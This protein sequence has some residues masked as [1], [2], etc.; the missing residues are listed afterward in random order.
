MAEYVVKLPDVGE[1]VAEAELVEWHVKPGDLVR[2]D[3]VLAA[4]MTDKA[5][6]EI[7]SPV[8]GDIFPRR[9]CRRHGR[10]RLRVDPVEGG[11]P[12]RCAGRYGRAGFDEFKRKDSSECRTRRIE[13]REAAEP[14]RQPAP[15]PRLEPCHG[16]AVAALPVWR[17]SVPGHTRGPPRPEKRELTCAKSRAPVQRAAS[18]TTTLMC[19]SPMASER[20]G[21]CTYQ[22]KTSVIDVKVVGLRRKIAEKMTQLLTR[23]FRT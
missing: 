5:T 14:P 20:R 1:G 3:A 7:P 12:G 2:E 22:A 17:G 16:L 4:V 9:R 18:P 19:S 11:G 13:R 6:V 23:A 21:L 10:G 8:E 15:H